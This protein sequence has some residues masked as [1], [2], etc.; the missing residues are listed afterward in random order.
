M[1]T[2]KR[3]YKSEDTYQRV[4]FWGARRTTGVWGLGNRGSVGQEATGNRGSV[5]QEAMTGP[6]WRGG[7]CRS[8]AMERPGRG[9]IGDEERPGRRESGLSGRPTRECRGGR[10]GERRDYFGNAA[11]MSRFEKAQAHATFIE[12]AQKRVFQTIQRRKLNVYR[13]GPNSFELRTVFVLSN[14][15]LFEAFYV[16]C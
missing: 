2:I 11:P 15:V 3:S 10:E 5:G 4:G 6:W 8:V 9:R 7:D 16:S 1:Y 14:A 12:A 13:G